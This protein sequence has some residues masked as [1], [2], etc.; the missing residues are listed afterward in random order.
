MHE[1][2]ELYAREYILVEGRMKYSEKEFETFAL[3][4]QGRFL[5]LNEFIDARIYEGLQRENK[6]RNKKS[7][8]F[9]LAKRGWNFTK[10]N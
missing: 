6:M 5:N 4:E 7:R 2:Q 3:M 10:W 9:A 1:C 8:G